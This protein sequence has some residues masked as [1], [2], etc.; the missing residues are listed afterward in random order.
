[1][2][3]WCPDV[4]EGAP[5]EITTWLSIASK[6]AGIGLLL[7]L[8][9]TFGGAVA[10]SSADALMWSIGLLAAVTCTIG[11]LAA[12]RQ[13]SVKRTLAYSSIAHAGYMMMVA[14]LLKSNLAGGAS[15]AAVAAIIS[16]LLIY[17]AMNVGA[18]C[19]TAVVAWHAGSDHLGA[20]TS[21]GRRAPWL[22]LPMAICL[23]SLVGL[24]P[25][26]GFTA[27]WYLLLALG[28]G[29][30]SQPWLWGLVI[31]AVLNTVVSLYYYVR[32]IR[33]MYLVDDASL[34]MIAPPASGV[35]L[36]NLCALFLLLT[37]TLFFNEVG[38]NAA[39]F[40]IG[41]GRGVLTP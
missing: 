23:F 3:L 34:P 10:A 30:A 6:A 18:F 5:V 40:A 28:K 31:V 12:L 25:L 41:F 14:P 4:F 15:E 2:H 22:A 9:F 16:Y 7:R 19:V 36:A 8:T 13:E 17:V 32:I 33:Q 37:G 27:K 35:L 20:F 39:L 21:L 11:N 24:P 38:T 29:A 26:G 1:M